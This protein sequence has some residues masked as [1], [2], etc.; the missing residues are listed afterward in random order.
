MNRAAT[1]AEH[2]HIL[3]ILQEHHEEDGAL[4][5]VLHDIQDALGHVPEHAIPV[6]A[7]ALHLSR[8]D[9][10]GVV[11]YYHHFRQTPP[12]NH[13]VHICQAEAC[14]ARGAGALLAHAQAHPGCQPHDARIAL[15]P[16][17]C[18][19]QCAV[20]PNLLVDDQHLLGRVDAPKF[21]ALI[22]TLKA[23]P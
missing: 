2:A 8:A 14:L 23:K 18:L 3:R 10:Y 17:Y 11:T 1:Q 19:G 13:V 4:L 15:E 20:G 6:I 5:P 21:D 12:A 7:K 22:Q 9:V 16:V